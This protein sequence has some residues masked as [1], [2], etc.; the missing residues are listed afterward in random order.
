M[1]CLVASFYLN[2]ECKLN[3]T[4]DLFGQVIRYFHNLLPKE[5]AN[6]ILF[7][8]KSFW[9]I[10][11]DNSL[12]VSANTSKWVNHGSKLFLQNFIQ[13]SISP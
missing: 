13:E 2:V 6:A 12:V 8:C 3:I 9:L 5:S 1:N 11:S 4:D 10:K 7:D